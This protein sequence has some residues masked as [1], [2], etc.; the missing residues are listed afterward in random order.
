MEI[1][2]IPAEEFVPV[3]A[4]TG[5]QIVNKVLYQIYQFY[6]T[7]TQNFCYV[8]VL[9]DRQLLARYFD[10]EN[11]D[12][13]E[14]YGIAPTNNL[15]DVST[16]RAYM[17]ILKQEDLATG[18][19]LQQAIQSY[20]I[21]QGCSSFAS[22]VV[23]CDFDTL[24]QIQIDEMAARL[25]DAL[26]PGCVVLNYP[27]RTETTAVFSKR[28]DGYEYVDVNDLVEDKVSS[29]DKTEAMVQRMYTL[30]NAVMKYQDSNDNTVFYL[31]SE[32]KF[33]LCEYASLA[34][35]SILTGGKR[36]HCNSNTEFAVMSNYLQS[37]HKRENMYLEDYLA[38][39][40]NYPDLSVI[41]N[42]NAYVLIKDVSRLRREDC[43]FTSVQLKIDP[44]TMQIDDRASKNVN[45]YFSD[46]RPL[47]LRKKFH[48]DSVDIETA[49][50]GFKE[51]S[52]LMR[53]VDTYI[54]ADSDIL[55]ESTLHVSNVL[56]YEYG[57]SVYIGYVPYVSTEV[58]F[59]VYPVSDSFKAFRTKLNLQEVMPLDVRV[60]FDWKLMAS[61]MIAKGLVKLPN[62][63]FRPTPYARGMLVSAVETSQARFRDANLCT[64][65]ELGIWSLQTR[66]TRTN[67]A[68]LEY[69]RKDYLMSSEFFTAFGGPHPYI[70]NSFTIRSDSWR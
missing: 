27:L 2:D 65:E 49:V 43:V 1:V 62:S 19:I 64:F 51:L 21:S 57:G 63:L 38:F 36:F 35:L 61:Q 5:L 30:Y 68:A 54:S 52:K 42:Q 70:R 24:S 41:V 40:C 59:V 55:K 33:S 31:G 22:C 69:F 9:Q 10:T 28:L 44:N 47:S 56:L 14:A 3:P 60:F 25:H 66:V 8:V 15:L 32:D 11:L 6:K 39:M 53:N 18:K 46:V 7:H 23:E 26:D 4:S 17:L 50:R 20:K 45:Y 48:L 12:L 29:F 16:N 34:A 13:Y 58:P 67:P 37:V